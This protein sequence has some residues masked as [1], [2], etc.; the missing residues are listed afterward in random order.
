VAAAIQ[1]TYLDIPSAAFSLVPDGRRGFALEAAA[2]FAARIARRLLSRRPRRGLT[3]NINIPPPPLCGVR[4]TSL[5]VNRYDPE[6]VPKKDPRGDLYYWIGSGSP[7][8]SGGTSSDVRAVKEGY[9]SI[10]PL[11]TDLTDYAAM[12]RPETAGLRKCFRDTD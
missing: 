12:D 5:G 10:T 4:I 8:M 2:R 7:R 11:H 3:L 1:G 6:I 9:I